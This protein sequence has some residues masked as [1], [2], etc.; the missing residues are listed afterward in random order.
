MDTESGIEL[1]WTLID[2]D[3]SAKHGEACHLKFS[4]AFGSPQL[5]QKLLAYKEL[6][7]NDPITPNAGL[8]WE[9]WMLRPENQ[10]A[11]CTHIDMWSFGMLLYKLIMIDA[12][13]VFLSTEADNIV[14][15]EDLWQLAYCWE[16]RKLDEIDRIL[17]AQHCESAA[18]EQWLAAVDLT[19][20]CLQ[21]VPR[22]RPAS[23]DRV[24]AHRFFTGGRGR[25]LRTAE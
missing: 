13:S 17:T 20:W 1:A 5:A 22:R 16:L 24:L 4:S 10:I 2:L 15:E 6:P 3:A 12:P 18:G 14:R 21:T 9:E 11:A 23:F 25:H 8:G 19:L 7:A